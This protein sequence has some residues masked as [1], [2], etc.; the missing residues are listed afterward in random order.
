MRKDELVR[1]FLLPHWEPIATLAVLFVNMV[2]MVRGSLSETW[3]ALAVWAMNIILSVFLGAVVLGAFFEARRQ[4]QERHIPIVV[5]VGQDQKAAKHAWW[6]AMKALEQQGLNP[7][8][9]LDEMTWADMYLHEPKRPANTEEWQGLGDRFRDQLLELSKLFHEH[10]NLVFHVFVVGPEKGPN[11]AAFVL[12]QTIGREF[13]IVVY[14]KDR[15][16]RYYPVSTLD[17]LRGL[18]GPPPEVREM[19]ADLKYT[20]GSPERLYL[21][22]GIQEGPLPNIWQLAR[23]KDNRRV[24]SISRQR[25]EPLSTRDDWVHITQEIAQLISKVVEDAAKENK[26][27]EPEVYLGLDVPPALAML[28]GM[29]SKECFRHRKVHVVYEWDTG[30]AIQIS[31]EAPMSLNEGV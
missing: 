21:A 12:G 6:M 4:M 24:Y 19:E 30:K 31:K 26:E 8:V 13:N 23:Q 16:V 1:Y 18:H 15:D 7:R 5:T 29:L 3:V 11:I 10:R 20:Q 28:L 25:K 9:N 27:T 2:L 17:A 22:V 14:H